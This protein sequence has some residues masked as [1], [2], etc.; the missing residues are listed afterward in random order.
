[1]QLLA[2]SRRAVDGS[3]TIL[4]DVAQATGPVV[5]GRWQELQPFLPDER[6]RDDR[7]AAARLPRAGRDHGASRCR[8]STV[9]APGAEP[10]LAYRQGGA[11]PR[12]VRV[13]EERAAR[14]RAAGGF[15]SSTACSP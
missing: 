15:A 12:F 8:C 2:V 10:P 9:I 5:Y 1:M 11:P 7:G 6:R 4:G 13:A 3:L 14:R